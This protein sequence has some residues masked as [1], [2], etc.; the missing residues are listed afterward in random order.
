MSYHSLDWRCHA[1]ERPNQHDFVD[2][3]GEAPR[4]DAG[5][6][7]DAPAG[8]G[9]RWESKKT[10]TCWSCNHTQP[11]APGAVD[12]GGNLIDPL[13]VC[14]A[15]ASNRL[16]S[17]KDFNRKLGVAIVIAGAALSPWTY[18]LSLVVCMGL[19]YGLYRFVPEITVCYACDAIH[20]G[21]QHN[22]AHRAH[23][24]LLA[25]RFRR[26]ARQELG[27]EEETAEARESAASEIAKNPSITSE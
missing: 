20:R 9:G 24:P 8:E 26:E 1:C 3:P 25:E 22:P 17:Q 23:D 5:A 27:L 11:L 4:D 21:F 14:G 18:G 7:S 12:A 13:E 2:A 15:C 10:L 6:A 16:Y 19:D